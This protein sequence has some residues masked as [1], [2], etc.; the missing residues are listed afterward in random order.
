M[1]A[2]SE[3][4]GKDQLGTIGDLHGSAVDIGKEDFIYKTSASKHR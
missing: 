4:I 1:T 3:M 2:M